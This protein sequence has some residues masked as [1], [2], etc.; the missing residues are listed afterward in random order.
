MQVLAAYIKKK[1][2]GPHKHNLF[3]TSFSYAA[4]EL[5]TPMLYVLLTLVSSNSFCSP[6]YIESNLTQEKFDP[7]TYYH[8]L[9]FTS[10]IRLL[11]FSKQFWW[12]TPKQAYFIKLIEFIPEVFKF[13]WIMRWSVKACWQLAVVIV[14][15]FAKKCHLWSSTGV[16]TG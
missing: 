16:W 4:Y 12:Y 8:Y 1:E 10:D 13:W 9:K 5:K 15:S 2:F 3:C 14:I 7:Y 6:V 11:L